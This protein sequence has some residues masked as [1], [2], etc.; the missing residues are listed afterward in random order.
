MKGAAQRGCPHQKH[1]ATAASRTSAR[2]SVG[3]SPVS[4]RNCWAAWA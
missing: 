3:L 2:Y 4:L 1:S